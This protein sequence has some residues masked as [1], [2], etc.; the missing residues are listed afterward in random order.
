M[1]KWFS[2]SDDQEEVSMLVRREDKSGFSFRFCSSTFDRDLFCQHFPRCFSK[3]CFPSPA[4]KCFLCRSFKPRISTF[5]F[6]TGL[7]AER[8]GDCHV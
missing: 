2:L 1:S 3:V 5:V 4:S 7:L 8:E 6:Y